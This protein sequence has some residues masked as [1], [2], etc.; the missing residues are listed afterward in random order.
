MDLQ[1]TSTALFASAGS[2]GQSCVNSE[3]PGST[4]SSTFTAESPPLWREV[5]DSSWVS[6]WVSIPL[7]PLRS[8]ARSPSASVL[9]RFMGVER[10]GCA[11]PRA[12]APRWACTAL[13]ARASSPFGGGR[14]AARASS[15]WGDGR[16]AARASGGRGF[17]LAGVLS[18]SSARGCRAARTTPSR[19]WGDPPEP[20]RRGWWRPAPLPAVRRTSEYAA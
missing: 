16:L 14:L 18:S 6:W 2:P 19:Y 3:S 8:R 4:F 7:R 20:A 9:L 13:A 1:R 5:Q 17:M 11:G 10:P 15:P 12:A